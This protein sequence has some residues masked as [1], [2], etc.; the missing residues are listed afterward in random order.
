MPAELKKVRRV[1]HDALNAARCAQ[2][3]ADWRGIRPPGDRHQR[4]VRSKRQSHH[5]PSQRI[6]DG[7]KYPLPILD[8]CGSEW[9]TYN[10]Y[11][12]C[13]TDIP[14]D[15]NHHENA[16]LR[17][18]V[19]RLCGDSYET[20]QHLITECKI[21]RNRVDKYFE[22]LTQIHP[23]GA[24]EAQSVPEDELYDWIMSGG[25]MPYPLEMDHSCIFVMGKSV[26]QPVKKEHK[27]ECK[28]AEDEYRQIAESLDKEAIVVFTDG[29]RLEPIERYKDL[30]AKPQSCGAGWVIYEHSKKIHKGSAALGDYDQ[31][32]GELTAIERSLEWL[33]DHRPGGDVH[34][35]S[36]SDIS[37][38]ALT[39]PGVHT[40]YYQLVQHARCIGHRPRHHRTG[41]SYYTMTNALH[42]TSRHSLLVA[43]QIA[44]VLVVRAVYTRCTIDYFNARIGGKGCSESLPGSGHIS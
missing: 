39:D 40:R 3:V 10:K 26:R 16:D 30:P 36:D 27:S 28:R 15:T 32:V 12:T 23:P 25:L 33:R 2:I 38:K 42:V 4:K 7:V 24:K 6:A 13:S 8:E 22:R 31:N 43:V 17:C 44:Y 35:F 21:T 29:S 9:R 34:I 37:C 14:E 5:L 1:A 41:R 20:K 11:Y 18:H 19:C